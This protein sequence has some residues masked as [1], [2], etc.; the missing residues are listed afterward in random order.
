MF[1]AHVMHFVVIN[2]TLTKT[3]PY[4]L[5]NWLINVLFPA[6]FDAFTMTRAYVL[7]YSVIQLIVN[8]LDLGDAGVI[9]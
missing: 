5:K 7:F 6:S 2:H 3:K 4:I 9:K 1:D 8:P